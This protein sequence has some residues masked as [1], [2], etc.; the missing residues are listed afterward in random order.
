MAHPHCV[1]P[2]CAR[3]TGPERGF[4]LCARCRDE[5]VATLSELPRLYQGCEKLLRRRYRD[6]A[7]AAGGATPSAMGLTEAVR[8]ARRQL[9]EALAGWCAMT[10]QERGERGPDPSKVHT[11]AVFLRKNANWLAAH[12]QAGDWAADIAEMSAGLGREHSNRRQH[13]A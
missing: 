13:V 6:T 4:R 12:P 2:H 1:A 9:R 11:M 7:T 10:A 3:E 5:L 8:V